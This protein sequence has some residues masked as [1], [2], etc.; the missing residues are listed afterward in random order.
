MYLK[1]FLL[2]LRAKLK[3]KKFYC[4][5]LAGNSNYNICV[6]SDMSVSCNC[7]D[8]DGTGRIGDLNKESL[9]EIFNGQQ[10]QALRLSLAKGKIPIKTCLGC[11][12][13]REIE[14]D[15]AEKY[16]KNF[17]LPC[18]GIMVENTVSCNLN[19]LCCNRKLVESIRAKKSLS[20]EDL[21]KISG[22]IKGNKIS[23][24]FYFNLGEP[25]LSRNI[26]K[27]LKILKEN[28]SDLIIY[29][30]TNGLLL[31]NE[32]KREACLKYV[33]YIFF[34]IDG[35]NNKTLQKYQ[36]Q[37]DFDKAYHNMKMLVSYRDSK[38]FNK[39]AIEWKYVLFR[40]NDK[41]SHIDKAI[42]LAKEAKV[43]IISFWPGGGSRWIK[44]RRY[45]TGDF[46][47]VGEKS[48]KGREVVLN[49]AK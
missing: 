9:R 47:N 26:H 43:D 32:D 20:I 7:Q 14:A 5:A 40:W 44:S 25:F 49:R 6:N 15:L 33:D 10:A 18:K 24:V 48:W 13:L 17:P 34:S 46:N 16:T 1:K 12:E 19:C 38:K 8:W 39:P 22:E 36:R 23:C 35:I 27:E 29:I 3:K 21:K 37:G 2:E 11:M 4:N 31:D 28:N 30:S 45:L 42:E 41:K